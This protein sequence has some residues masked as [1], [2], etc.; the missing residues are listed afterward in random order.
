[1]V[2]KNFVYKSKDY[3]ALVKTIENDDNHDDNDD[4]D[5]D[6]DDNDDDNNDDDDVVNDDADD[7]EQESESE[8]ASSG[9]PP[10]C[11]AK[12]AVRSSHHPQH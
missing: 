8:A 4:N 3:Y 6:N 12:Q 2:I 9:L 7:D 11:D 5:D 10:D 1:M